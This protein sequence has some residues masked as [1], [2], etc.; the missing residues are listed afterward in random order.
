[1][2]TAA[3]ALATMS[4]VGDRG[5]HA[6]SSSAG[7]TSTRQMEALEV[8]LMSMVAA[9]LREADKLTAF[10]GKNVES[11]MDAL[12]RR[13]SELERRFSELAAAPAATAGSAGR[14][15]GQGHGEC[16][17]GGGFERQAEMEHDEELRQ[18]AEAERQA[19][20]LE[21]RLEDVEGCRLG[22]SEAERS[23]RRGRR[24]GSGCAQSPKF[25][26]QDHVLIAV[27]ELEVLLQEE[28]KAVHRRCSVFQDSIDER[29][30]MPLRDFEQRLQEQDQKV[31]QLV[32]AG[33]DC[34]SRLE[35]HEFRLGVSRT[36]LEMHDQKISRLEAMRWQRS[37]S[38]IGSDLGEREQY[39]ERFGS[40][41]SSGGSGAGLL[42]SNSPTGA[43]SRP[44]HEDLQ[45]SA[46]QPLTS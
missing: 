27:Q 32:V 10:V 46:V 4:A 16:S 39:R 5:F 24:S 8:K 35:E 11:R 36:K 13:F 23:P 6:V 28:V 14:E 7:T 1:M 17:G 21:R 33:Q 30:M 26:S 34:S 22:N 2:S 31:R 41:G 3:T 18:L 29:V 9:H 15:A 12:E 37:S 38:G 43:S 20:E 44:L 40:C 42:S 19:E 25:S 45:R